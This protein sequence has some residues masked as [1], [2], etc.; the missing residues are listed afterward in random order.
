MAVVRPDAEVLALVAIAG[1]NLR[2]GDEAVAAAVE[3]AA[4][5]VTMAVLQER[6]QIESSVSLWG[7]LA[8]E[9]LDSPNLDRLR[10]HAGALAYDLDR[11]HRV[12]LIVPTEPAALSATAVAMQRIAPQFG[13][14]P[15]VATERD[16]ALVLLVASDLNWG[17]LALELTDESEVSLE[18]AVGGRYDRTLA[19][20]SRNTR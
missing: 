1:A 16:D 8:S 11:P 12:L 7:D 4:D 19:A 20:L 13:F 18:I 2:V 15:P 17:Q 14:Y 9:L 5:A 3:Q 10:A 6:T